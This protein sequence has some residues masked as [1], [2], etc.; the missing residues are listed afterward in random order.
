LARVAYQAKTPEDFLDKLLT[1]LEQVARKRGGDEVKLS[2]RMEAL[3]ALKDFEV[4]WQLRGIPQPIAGPFQNESGEY[5]PFAEAF[6]EYGS[7]VLGLLFSG[8]V[9]ERLRS[10]SVDF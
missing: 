5:Q 10:V 2:L 8:V 3:V 1:F 6:P 4:Q 7:M 9:P